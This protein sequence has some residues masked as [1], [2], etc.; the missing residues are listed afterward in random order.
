MNWALWWAIFNW[1]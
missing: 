1:W